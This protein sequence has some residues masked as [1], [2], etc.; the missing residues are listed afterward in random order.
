MKK[1]IK[2]SLIEM[3]IRLSH[4]SFLLNDMFYFDSYAYNLIK[5][6]CGPIAITEVLYSNPAHTHEM[7]GVMFYAINLEDF[8]QY[9][10][11]LPVNN[12]DTS[13]VSA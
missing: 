11:T 10:L 2:L 6:N 4:T 8:Y 7:D 12:R 5:T 13:E 3:A 9:L 1:Y